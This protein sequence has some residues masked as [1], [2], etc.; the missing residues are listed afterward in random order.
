MR[1]TITIAALAIAMTGCA[2]PT[3]LRSQSPD[4]STSSS[5]DANTVASCIAEQWEATPMNELSISV[6]PIKGGH[7]VS[8]SFWGDTPY[9]CQVTT[10]GNGSRTVFYS[11]KSAYVG[12]YLQDIKDCQ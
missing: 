2:T 3:Q 10:Q 11:R 1:K 7:S 4:F 6:R 9:L 5:K 12:G 8:A